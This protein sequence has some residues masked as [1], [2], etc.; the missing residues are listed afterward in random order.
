MDMTG[1]YYALVAGDSKVYT[2]SSYIA[3][4]FEKSLDDLIVVE[5]NIE[6]IAEE[7]VIE[8]ATEE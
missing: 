7:S 5:E 3:S 4:V 8:A 1:E 2:I 6:G